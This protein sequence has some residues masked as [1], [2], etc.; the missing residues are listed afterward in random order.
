MR[1][2]TA[3]AVAAARSSRGPS[4]PAGKRAPSKKRIHGGPEFAFE[5]RSA[6]SVEFLVRTGVRPAERAA[7]RLLEAQEWLA[8]QQTDDWVSAPPGL[9]LGFPQV[10][11]CLKLLINAGVDKKS[12]P[13]SLVA[14]PG[15]LALPPNELDAR[16]DALDA[17]GLERSLVPPTY[18]PGRL[19]RALERAPALL[20]LSPPAVEEVAEALTA[21]GVDDVAA[22]AVSE[23]A[24]LCE[25]LEA[26]AARASE[27]TALIGVA[28]PALGALVSRHPLLLAPMVGGTLADRAAF[29]A[30]AGVAGP[31][32]ASLVSAAPAALC[33]SVQR[34]LRPKA[35]FAAEELGLDAAAAA[36]RCPALFGTVNLERTVRPRAAFLRHLGVSPGA[37]AD[38]LAEWATGSADAFIV[39]A[40]RLAPA[41]EVT[42]AAFRE[43]AGLAAPR[44]EDEA[45]GEAEA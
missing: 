21:L 34:S 1:A 44:G 22:L 45:D 24:V 25:P 4:A 5:G 3:P 27:L 42:V 37:I 17:L 6:N 33:A 38:A 43:H 35:A 19:G 7:A 8:T 16:L 31:A 23:P 11:D 20:A 14:F 12:L 28:P 32:L 29:W 2:L 13:R 9:P 26:L 15:V 39:V 40:A 10:R 36:A 41:S 30:E 18:M